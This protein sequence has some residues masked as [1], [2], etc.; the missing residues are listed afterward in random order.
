MMQ[1]KLDKSTVHRLRGLTDRERQIVALVCAG[2]PNKIIARKLHVKEG[3]V[4]T[5]LHAI[6]MKLGIENRASL[7]G[8]VGHAQ[9]DK[10]SNV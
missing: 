2:H 10:I 1:S 6:Y 5:H 4:K 9:S 8:A 7:I 3:T